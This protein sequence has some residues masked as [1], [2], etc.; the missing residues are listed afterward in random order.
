MLIHGSFRKNS[1]SERAASW[2]SLESKPYDI[3]IIGGGI[4][5][6]GIARDAASRGLSVLLIEKKDFAW[7]TSSRS[8]KLIHGG[9][10]YLENFEFHLVKESTHERARLWKLAPQLVTP[11][12]FLFPAY[13]DSR[14]PLWKLNIGLWLYDLLSGFQVPQVHQKFSPKQLAEMEPELKQK[15][16]TGAIHYFDGATDDA[17]LTLAN[18]IDAH[19]LGAKVLSRVECLGVTWNKKCSESPRQFHT[20]ELEDKIS[21]EKKSVRCR[22]VVSAAGPWTDEVAS[23]LGKAPRKLLRTT[24]GS[25]I[26]VPGTKLPLKHAVVMTHPQDGRVLF[27]IPWSDYSIIGTTDIDDAGN[28]ESTQTTPEE[29]DYLLQSAMTYFPKCKLTRHD[30]VSTWTGLRP[31]IAPHENVSESSVSREHFMDF[32]DPGF[33]LIAGGKLTTFRQM[34]EDSVDRILAETRKWK[35]PLQNVTKATLTRDRPL[36]YLYFPK[37]S[38]GFLG[39]T[40]ASRM[41]LSDVESILL[42]QLVFSLEDFMVRRT[43]LFYKE[44]KN[45]VPLLDKLKPAFQK[46]LEWDDEKWN[47]E[48]AS[49][50]AYVN[51]N[52]TQVLQLG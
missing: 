30:V 9:V 15:D 18:I 7:G 22:V 45:G 3:V 28:P 16:L 29:V 26:V 40:E 44:E 25:H 48:V 4:T 6:A 36:P 5:G 35:V 38:D 14:V 50:N 39:L 17:K 43:S 41:N 37:A 21:G 31:L 19:E 12:P 23:K 27:A 11:M 52:V 13:K 33:L 51:H 1:V 24:R 42:T 20:V 47:S 34:A 2:S 8:S 46:I 49:Y 10:R 32:I